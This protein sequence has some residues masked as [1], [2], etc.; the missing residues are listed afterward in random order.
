MGRGWG[1]I[2][3]A[4]DAFM[5]QPPWARWALGVPAG[6]L[7]LVLVVVLADLA[8]AAGRIHPG[9]R[10][11]DVKVGGLGRDSAAQHVAEVLEPRLEETVTV[12][13]EDVEWSI[14]ATT[15]GASI[16]PQEYAQDA[17]EV[18]RRGSLWRRVRERSASW[19]G[20][21]AVQANVSGEPTAT[22]ALLD[23]FDS[24]I[25]VDAVD[26]S[27]RIEGTEVLLD[28]SSV[29][30]AVDR[31]AA[32]REI[33]A[34]F[35][36]DERRV[37]LSTRLVPAAVT[38]A[39]ARAAMED[40][41]L[42][43]S[44][45]LRIEYEEHDW[46]IAP[47]QI[48]EWIA[49]RTVPYRAEESSAAAESSVAAGSS[50]TT[51]ANL[52]G[53]MVLEAFLVTQEVS[54]TI[55]PL[56]GEV[57]RQAKDA[58]FR[59]SAGNVTI[60]PSEVGLGVD[61]DA[62]TSELEV[63]LRKQEPDLRGAV[64]RMEAIQPELTT[65]EAES[66]GIKERLATFTTTFSS[67]NAPRVNN[68]QTLASA[69][70]GTLIPPG[71]QFSFNG[72]VGPRTAE[73]GYEEAGTIVDGRLVPTLGG[74]ICQVCTTLFNS[75]FFSGL[76]VDQRTNHSFYISHYPKGRDATVS[77][78][79]P[80]F[81]F[82]NDTSSWVL[83]AT[84]YSNSSVTISLYGTDPGY[85]V[86]YETGPWTDVKPHDVKEIEDDTLEEGVRIV[87]DGGVDGRTIVVTRKVYDEAGELVREDSFRSR[88]NPKTEYV[89]V[90]TKPAPR[91]NEGSA[92][93]GG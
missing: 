40:A 88:Y 54:S 74:G 64:L 42:M 78:G 90:G 15:V 34:A 84:G 77:W 17:Y 21:I 22:E 28:P 85:R 53:R 76:Q 50:E 46:E 80:D 51:A 82:S 75:V 71:G 86:E 41:R 14:E 32:K 62:L 92:S 27:V 60:V 13:Y 29:G 39:D 43:L 24:E 44:G 23:R 73:K 72:S 81:K 55:A 48:A 25:G 10:V 7:A 56:T 93:A 65:E 70:D 4:K 87:E 30:L 49:F 68:I 35:L 36:A 20:G 66:M 69:L 79:G 33:L 45:P 8:I 52:P 26:A 58:E 5:R 6:L 3:R 11:D 91:S 38:D 61:M 16:A 2:L 18:G 12:V 89:R 19:F 9:V 37:E 31:E 57:W 1:R 47:E 67:S 59:A 63:A 83:I